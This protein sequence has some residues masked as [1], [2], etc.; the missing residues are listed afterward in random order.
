MSAGQAG[1]APMRLMTMRVT[2]I[3]DG[4]I[5]ERRDEVCVTADEPLDPFALTSA[6]P[7]CRCP[8]CRH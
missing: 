4:E 1:K 5:I 8:R 7:P 2:R 6:W 3:H